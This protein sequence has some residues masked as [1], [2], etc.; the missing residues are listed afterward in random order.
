MAEI[1]IVQSVKANKDLIIRRTAIVTGAVLGLA[2]AGTLL[3]V[4]SQEVQQS[5]DLD[6]D[7]SDINIETVND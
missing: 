4:K 7:G 3:V 5:E 6:A 2:I 1:Q